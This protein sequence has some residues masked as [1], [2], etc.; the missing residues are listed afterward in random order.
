MISPD[1]ILDLQRR[2]ALASLPLAALSVPLT[3]ESR[4]A[5]RMPAGILQE[6]RRLFAR[7]AKA[8]PPHPL[9]IPEEAMVWLPGQTLYS[10]FF[11]QLMPL[12]CY[13]KDWNCQ[14]RGEER[15]LFCTMAHP[16]GGVPAAINLWI[17]PLDAPDIL[18]PG[19]MFHVN[20]CLFG[21]MLAYLERVLAALELAGQRGLG[22]GWDETRGR[23]SVG[24]P[25]AAF[26]MDQNLAVPERLVVRFI[27][28]VRSKHVED[29]GF[30]WLW[31]LIRSR[32]QFG[33]DKRWGSNAMR[34]GSPR[35]ED[36]EGIEVEFDDPACSEEAWSQKFDPFDSRADPL[37]VGLQPDDALCAPPTLVL[38]GDLSPF[39]PGLLLAE[40]AGIGGGTGK[41]LGR[42]ELEPLG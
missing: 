41:G 19:D 11:Q 28:P 13:Y 35:H 14:T 3:A 38:T 33:L 15:C 39:W 25:Q 22:P 31:T 4:I 21:P 27:T 12:M 16:E 18:E 29:F 37:P 32:L 24:A 42:I 9:V 5:L 17:D 6:H 10:G 1:Q 30:T 8:P 34:V 7:E 40:A 36:H 20:I 2:A 26:A 23:F